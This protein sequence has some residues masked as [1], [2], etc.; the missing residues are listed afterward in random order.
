MTD[1]SRERRGLDRGEVRQERH[2]DRST[3][4]LKPRRAIDRLGAEEI[5]SRGQHA[6][7][8]WY[9]AAKG[10]GFLESHDE[11]RDIF[12][13]KSDVARYNLNEHALTPGAPVVYCADG[14]TARGQER[15]A[16]LLA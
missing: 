13:H 6:R 9:D 16:I 8:K 2:G 4:A 1:Y 3:V 5:K 11:G 7:V 10:Y 14:R 12:V 15:I